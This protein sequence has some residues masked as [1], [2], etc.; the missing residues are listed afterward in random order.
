MFLIFVYAINSA[1]KCTPFHTQQDRSTRPL[2]IER[3]LNTDVVTIYWRFTNYFIPIGCFGLLWSMVCTRSCL[4]FL[5][6]GMGIKNEDEM[7]I[8]SE[9][10]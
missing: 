6:L 8:F 2:P 5:S 1:N 10:H 7:L 3:A 9:R 4:I